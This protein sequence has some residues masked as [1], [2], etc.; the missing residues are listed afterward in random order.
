MTIVCLNAVRG[1]GEDILAGI[2]VGTGSELSNYHTFLCHGSHVSIC[3]DI[4][5]T[6]QMSPM[7]IFH[8]LDKMWYKII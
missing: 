8:M 4:P 3:L 7:M 5:V 1:P 6:K 2:W